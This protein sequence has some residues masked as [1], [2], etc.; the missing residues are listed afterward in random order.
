MVCIGCDEDLYEEM[1]NESYPEADVCGYNYSAGYLLR[2]IDSIAFRCGMND[3]TCN[4]EEIENKQAE[5]E[6]IEEDIERIRTEAKSDDEVKEMID[7]L[8]ATAEE[9]E[10]D[11]STLKEEGGYRE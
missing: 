11:I 5:V 1:L 7:D 10:D 2:Q 4:C 8:E 3:H 9:L 6:K